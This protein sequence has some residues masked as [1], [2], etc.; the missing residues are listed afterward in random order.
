[1]C[2]L[3]NRCVL[4]EAGLWDVHH[5]GHRRNRSRGRGGLSR[6]VHSHGIYLRGKNVGNAILFEFEFSRPR[7]PRPSPPSAGRTADTTVSINIAV[8]SMVAFF[9]KKIYSNPVYVDIGANNGDSA[10]L[11]F[12]FM[13]TNTARTWDIKVTQ[14]ECS[15]PNAWVGTYFLE[16]NIST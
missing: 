8:L 6:H 10:T 16:K 15:N 4:L 13:G 2:V 11:N 3:K 7:P 1:M 5:P 9:I 12:N 14:V